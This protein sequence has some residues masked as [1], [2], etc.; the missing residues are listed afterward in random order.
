VARKNLLHDKTRL[1]MGLGGILFAVILMIF[2]VGMM[3]GT[4]EYAVYLADHSQADIWALG[5]LNGNV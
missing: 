4:L 5:Q 2:A 1:A 3:V